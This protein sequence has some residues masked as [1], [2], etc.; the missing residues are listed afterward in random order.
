MQ[1]NSNCVSVTYD[2]MQFLLII[3]MQ[4]FYNND[5]KFM[6]KFDFYQSYDFKYHYV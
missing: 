3:K 6:R 2:Y 4:I 1:K 5:L